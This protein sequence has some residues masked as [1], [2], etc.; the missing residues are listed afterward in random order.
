MYVLWSLCEDN[1]IDIL[2]FVEV[3]SFHKWED[4][5]L[6]IYMDSIHGN[7]IRNYLRNL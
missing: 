2:Q 5:I 7:G 1:R 6:T 4:E 3:Y